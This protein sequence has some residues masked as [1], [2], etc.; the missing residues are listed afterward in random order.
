MSPRPVYFTAADLAGFCGVDPKTI[1]NWARRGRIACFR[2]PGGHLR[3]HPVDALSFLRASGFAV[4]AA[5]VEA[6]PTATAAA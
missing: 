6:Q 4:P 1:H 5:V 2:T 3:V